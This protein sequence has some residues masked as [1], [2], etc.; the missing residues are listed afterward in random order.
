VPTR[1]PPQ[2][3]QLSVDGDGAG[4]AASPPIRSASA[5]GATVS[6]PPANGHRAGA[7]WQERPR[8]RVGDLYVAARAGIPAIRVETGAPSAARAACAANRHGPSA[9]W[10]ERAARVDNEIVPARP[11]SPPSELIPVLP[12]PPLPAAAPMTTGPAPP[13]TNVPPALLMM[14]IG[15]ATPP[16]PPSARAAPPLPPL[17][18]VLPIVTPALPAPKRMPPPELVTVTG[19]VSPPDPPEAEAAEPPLPPEPALLPMIRGPLVVGAGGDT[20]VVGVD[21]VPKPE[22][23]KKPGKLPGPKNLSCLAL[24]GRRP[25]ETGVASTPPAVKTAVAEATA[26]AV[27]TKWTENRMVNGWGCPLMVAAGEG[28]A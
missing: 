28:R 3:S 13:L 10:D 9:G 21:G 22:K 18:P 7:C 16:S 5:T 23:M 2:Q 15:P 26:A 4:V 25:V 24:A 20:G 1:H 8:R 27:A 11:P 12:S 19:P 14:S 17:P 6:A